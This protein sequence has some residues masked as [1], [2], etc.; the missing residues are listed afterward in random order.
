LRLFRGNGAKERRKSIRSGTSSDRRPSLIDMTTGR[1]RSTEDEVPSLIGLYGEGIGDKVLRSP[2]CMRQ[3]LA[4]SLAPKRGRIPPAN[5]FRAN[6]ALP[7]HPQSY[8]ELHIHP[9]TA[10]GVVGERQRAMQTDVGVYFVGVL[11]V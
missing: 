4:S 3:A 2:P 10:A 11:Q 9:K 7:P 8:D 5:D 1:T 6:S